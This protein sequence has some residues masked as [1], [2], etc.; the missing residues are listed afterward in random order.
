MET[1]DAVRFPPVSFATW[2]QRVIT[3]LSGG[4]DELA[5][6]ARPTLEGVPREPLCSADHA[7]ERAPLPRVL[8]APGPWRIW[9]EVP[10]GA[11][12][13]GAAALGREIDRGLGG[14]WVRSGEAGEEELAGRHLA[15]L[16][17][18]LPPEVDLA[19]E[20]GGEPLAVAALL[21][22]AARGAGR[23]LA[24]TAG[25][26]GCDPLGSAA[27]SGEL[28]AA[29]RNQL[30]AAARWAVEHAPR[31]R[32]GLVSS[33]PYHDAG[34]DAVQELAVTVATGVGYLRWLL[35]AGLS[36]EQAASQLLL[37][38]PVGRDFFLQVAKLRALRV[39]WAMAL[40]QHEAPADGIRVHARTSWRTKTRLDPATDLVRVTLEAMA[41][42][43]GGCDD[44]TCTPFLDPTVALELGLPLGSA[45]Q[46]LLREEAALG[47]VLDPAGGSWY[48]EALSGDLARAGWDLFLEIER[49]GGMESALAAGAIADW[50][51]EA[52]D[53]RRR[54]LAHRRLPLTGISSYPA[55]GTAELPYRA[56]ARSPAPPASE[57]EPVAVRLD[58]AAAGSAE[59]F[60]RA[61]EAAGR[62]ASAL[63]LAAALAGSGATRQVRSV[64]VLAAWRDA[65]PFEALRRLSRARSGDRRRAALLRLAP[66]A[67]TL[68]GADLA[69]QVLI[70][71][72]LSVIEP[73]PLGEP[74]SAA[75]AWAEAAADVAVVLPGRR[76]PAEQ[77]VVACHALRAAGCPVVIAVAGDEVADA[78]H[79]RLE[80]DGDV[81]ELLGD[82]LA[83]LDGPP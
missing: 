45:T 77:V 39:L 3:E 69:R 59:L 29:V 48:V 79:L 53:R 5:G 73:E 60:A 36:A 57:R 46:L 20:G 78:A 14:L 34:A 65:V 37:S 49:R 24:T 22:A 10:V 40:D 7:G 13:A 68:E 80:P 19:I 18:G 6:L 33:A 75:G 50:V 16:L 27:R 15:P 35:A 58:G 26:L 71:A 44:L 11:G 12:S 66:V 82:L 21:A 43:V 23:D 54:E 4:A 28:S 42:V 61:V 51:G 72:G 9:Q 38:V 63:A 25:C 62:G 17:A 70:A 31:W 8:R 2:R 83:G 64:P 56:A 41:A 52:A 81:L 67:A 1:R 32:A 55:P 76:T 47:Q 30:V 74:A